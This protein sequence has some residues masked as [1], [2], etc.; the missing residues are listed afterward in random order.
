MAVI[1]GT[2]GD[3]PH[4]GEE[5]QCT[6]VLNISGGTRNSTRLTSKYVLQGK[7]K[8][9]KIII[10]QLK[11]SLFLESRYQASASPEI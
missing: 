11:R 2:G 7:T 1:T 10:R 8:T 4:M 3:A 5:L 9:A 6:W